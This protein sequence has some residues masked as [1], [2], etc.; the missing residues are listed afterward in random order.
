MLEIESGDI[1]YLVDVGVQINTRFVFW[2]AYVGSHIRKC[3]CTCVPLYLLGIFWLYLGWSWWSLVFNSMVNKI[4][5]STGFVLLAFHFARRC[6]E[7]AFVHIYSNPTLPLSKLVYDIFQYGILLGLITCYNLFHPAYSSPN[8][9][10]LAYWTLIILYMITEVLNCCC[11]FTLMTLRTPNS[12]DY[13]IPFVWFLI[14]IGVW[15][16]LSIMCKS[17]MGINRNHCMGNFH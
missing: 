3:H 11:H 7:C 5:L 10:W 16:W 8:W 14:V 12:Y 6:L 1:I 17:S 13:A 15:R 4:K 2:R 9:S